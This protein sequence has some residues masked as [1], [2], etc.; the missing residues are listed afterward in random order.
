[1]EILH[2]PERRAAWLRE[3]GQAG[4]GLVGEVEHPQAIV[5]G[6]IESRDGAGCG[7]PFDRVRRRLVEA[8]RE[9]PSPL[10]ALADLAHHLRAHIHP[11][12]GVPVLHDAHGAPEGVVDALLGVQQRACTRGVGPHDLHL[13]GQVVACPLVQ[14]PVDHI[15]APE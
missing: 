5:V 2:H 10:T 7:V 6:R 15:G 9:P 8:A 14:V 11:V 12:D 4:D 1:M 13:R 3:L